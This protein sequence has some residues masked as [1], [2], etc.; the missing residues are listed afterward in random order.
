MIMY[1][2]VNVGA[3]PGGAKRY[4]AYVNGDYA[5]HAAVSK[6][7]PHARVFG[8]DVTGKGWEQACIFDYEPGCIFS[9]L[10]LRYA[11]YQREQFRPR[12][13]VVYCDRDNLPAVTAACDG[14]WYLVW[15]STLD[16]T[17]MTGERTAGGHLIAG[18]QVATVGG[19]DVSDVLD[20]WT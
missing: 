20:T 9:P 8:I 2:S 7:F 4:A 17:V 3:L 13:A 1:D 19:Y 16:G 14:L 18:T 5:N 15:I 12:T 11:V 6:R 10:T